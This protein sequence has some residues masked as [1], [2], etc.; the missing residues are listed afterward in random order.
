MARKFPAATLEGFKLIELFLES[1]WVA[2]SEFLV[3]ACLG[4]GFAC[5]GLWLVEFG[6]GDWG[7]ESEGLPFFTALALSALRWACAGFMD[8]SLG[9]LGLGVA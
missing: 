5:G 2:T 9:I 3:A 1:L 7:L 8:F 6:D 4:F